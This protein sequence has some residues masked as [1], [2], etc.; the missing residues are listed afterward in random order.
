MDV[1]WKEAKS[2]YEFHALDID[3]NDVHLEKYR[4]VYR[5]YTHRGKQG[6]KF[7]MFAKINVNGKD[8]HPL[9][10]Y[11]KSKQ[12]AFLFNTI[13]WNFSKFLINEEGQPIK[14]YGLTVNPFSNDLEQD[15]D[16]YFAKP[17]SG[18]LESDRLPAAAS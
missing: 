18:S 11:L 6:V 16:K 2:I 5:R 12:S 10:K 4:Y 7:D 15:L 17:P 14:R 13:K 9:W 1:N 3:G 8:A